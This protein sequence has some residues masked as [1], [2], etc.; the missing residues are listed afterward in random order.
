LLVSDKE[1]L[2]SQFIK[3]KTRLLSDPILIV[4]SETPHLT[5][6]LLSELDHRRSDQIICNEE[7]MKYC[8]EALDKILEKVA[9]RES[10]TDHDQQNIEI[11]GIV[12]KQAQEEGQAKDFFM[13][14]TGGRARFWGEQISKEEAKDLVERRVQALQAYEKER[15][16]D[17]PQM[18]ASELEDLRSSL[19]QIVKRQFN[20]IDER[21]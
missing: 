4:Y 14:I 5:N 19:Y 7:L 17:T 1:K 8:S 10:L 13:K 9:S 16:Y 21:E 20:V 12:Y 11:L 3:L 2:E 18:T 15:G 6:S